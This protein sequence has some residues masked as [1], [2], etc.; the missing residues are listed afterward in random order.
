MTI[1]FITNGRQTMRNDRT[2]EET[3][4]PPSDF[5]DFHFAPY[6]WWPVLK[7]DS[8]F[9]T[10]KKEREAVARP[11][12]V[13]IHALYLKQIQNEV[14]GF[15]KSL[16]KLPIISANRFQINGRR[17]GKVKRNYYSLPKGQ[18]SCL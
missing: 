7:A 18:S 13:R 6:T 4:K 2:R 8:L 15:A 9:Y 11:I 1:Q 16:T 12:L 5:A 14:A 3:F 17:K 10:P